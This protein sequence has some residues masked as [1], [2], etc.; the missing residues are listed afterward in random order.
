MGRVPE[1]TNEDRLELG[2]HGKPEMPGEDGAGDQGLRLPACL[3]HSVGKR[4]SRQ[5]HDSLHDVAATTGQKNALLQQA[6]R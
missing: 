3:R 4:C 1:S 6:I 5:G 2:F